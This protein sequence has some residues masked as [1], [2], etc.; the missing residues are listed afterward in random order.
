M[1]CREASRETSKCEGLQSLGTGLQLPLQESVP[2]RR[3]AQG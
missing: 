1:G 3:V 2:S